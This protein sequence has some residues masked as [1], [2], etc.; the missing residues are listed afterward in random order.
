MN[1]DCKQISV[2]LASI[3]FKNAGNYYLVV[4]FQH[5]PHLPVTY[6]TD[7][8]SKTKTPVYT[9]QPYVFDMDGYSNENTTHKLDT[10]L[11][12]TNKRAEVVAQTQLS[13]AESTPQPPMLVISAW[14]VVR[15]IQSTSTASQDP[16]GLPEHRGSAKIFLNDI[17]ST[18]E[19]NMQMDIESRM[20]PNLSHDNDTTRLQHGHDISEMKHSQSPVA[21]LTVQLRL[22]NTVKPIIETV[23][24]DH[25]ISIVS[26]P[27][28]VKSTTR[29]NMD[30]FPTSKSSIKA[31]RPSSSFQFKSLVAHCNHHTLLI[32]TL[33]K[34]VQTRSETIKKLERDLT[35]LRQAN[36]HQADTI[37]TLQ[38]RLEHVE[39]DTQRCLKT[40]D[41]D[42]VSDTELRRRYVVLVDRIQSVINDNKSMLKRIQTQ[43]Q[44]AAKHQDLIAKYTEL[45]QAHTA[46][47]A[48]LLKLQQDAR[49]SQDYRTTIKKQE[50]VIQK[51]ETLIGDGSGVASTHIM[52]ASKTM[53]NTGVFSSSSMADY[54]RAEKNEARCLSLEQ[55]LIRSSKEFGSQIASLKMRNLDLLQ[56]LVSLTGMRH[57]HTYST[58]FNS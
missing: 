5:P 46:Q 32:E 29:S 14:Q 39:L 34:D 15:R 47:Q 7:V 20:W 51:L 48:Y 45:R 2:S 18:L 42:L 27:S 17:W 43:K 35:R 8:S 30:P 26:R 28:S 19:H 53:T 54:M 40:V 21:T 13:C 37:Q 16:N 56:Q 22:I 23:L 12:A 10:F 38:Q 36:N 31:S 11:K 41:I 25:S 57:S 50:Q 1:S 52:D 49:S 6:T 4:E 33:I 24:H 3:H 44:E 58:P 9:N 55:E